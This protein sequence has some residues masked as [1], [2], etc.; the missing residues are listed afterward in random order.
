MK[1]VRH[2]QTSD[3]KL[4][5]TEREAQRHAELRY[6]EASHKL[7]GEAFNL[8]HGNGRVCD[9]AEW[10]ASNLSRFAELSRLKADIAMD[11]DGDPSIMEME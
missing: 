4:H 1:Q 8:V 10:I 9:I 7:G 11:D 5:K 2:F 6:T 3:G